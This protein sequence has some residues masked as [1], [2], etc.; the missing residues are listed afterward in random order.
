M[1]S[2]KPRDKKIKS[3]KIKGSERGAVTAR[4]ITSR[5]VSEGQ[6][7]K[8]PS[9]SNSKLAQ[10]SSRLRFTDSKTTLKGSKTAREYRDRATMRDDEF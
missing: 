4:N 8:K 1:L 9:I 3:L 5:K 2:K 6:K 7:R 10:K